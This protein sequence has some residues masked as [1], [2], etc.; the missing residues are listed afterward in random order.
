MEVEPSSDVAAADQCDV[1]LAAEQQRA[2][3]E[4]DRLRRE[5]DQ[6]EVQLERSE[7]ACSRAQHDLN[8]A[9][10]DLAAV[11]QRPPALTAG[12]AS[13]GS[14]LAEQVAA[15]VRQVILTQANSTAALY[16]DIARRLA[17]VEAACQQTT[18]APAASGPS[19][20]DYANLCERI[21]GL[22][23]Q[24]VPAGSTV[25]VISKGDD[26]LVQ[27]ADRRGW[28]FPQNAEG[29][30][31]GHH[32]A[33][34]TD[35]IAHLETLR[36]KG[37]T[38]LVVPQT[39]VWWRDFYSEFVNYLTAHCAT[40][41]DDPSIGLIYELG[42]SNDTARPAAKVLV[43][44]HQ[45]RHQQTLA[46]LG[47]PATH[48]QPSIQTGALPRL[49]AFY[50]PQYHPIPENDR[51]W[52]TGFTE[53]TNVTRA[54]PLFPGHY[55]PQLP[56]ELGFY[57]LRCLETQAA[58]ARLAA[59]FG[60]HGFCY[61]HYWFRG[62]RLLE[63]PF[64]QVLRTTQV[65]LPFCLCWA[66]EPWSRRWD[67]GNHEVL[68]AQSYSLADDHRHIR[69]LLPAL[70]DKRAIK[71][72]GCPIF[73]VYRAKDLPE[74]HRTVE[75]WRNEVKKAGLPGIHLIAV[76][77]SWDLGWDATK[78]GF[79]ARLLFQPC[80]ARLGSC[81]RVEIP[82]LPDLRVYDYEQASRL[83]AQPDPV[84]YRRYPSVFPNWDNTARAG[85]RAVV[86]RNSTPAA[87]ERWLERTVTE[88]QHEADEHKLI[89]INAWNE[90]AEGAHLEPDQRDQRGYLEATQRV[91]KRAAARGPQRPST[92]K[93]RRAAIQFALPP[94]L[95]E[96]LPNWNPGVLFDREWYVSQNPDIASTQLEPWDHYLRYGARQGRDPHPLFD[97][98]FYLKTY[99]QSVIECADPL[100]HYVTTG[101]K[102]G[103]QP[104]AKFDPEFYLS[105]YPDIAAHGVEPLTHFVTQGIKEGRLSSP[106]ELVVEPFEAEISISR[107]PQGKAAQLDP[108]I[109]PI[110]FFLPQFHAIP[111]NDKW[112]GKGFTEWTNVRS[113]K[114]Q[115]RAHYQPHVPTTL[116]YY[117]LRKGRQVLAEQAALAQAHGIYGF[118]LYYYWFA[119]K[120][121]L[122]LPLNR[123]LETGEPAMPFCICWANE[124]W[125]RRWDGM[126]S[127]ILIA[128]QHSPKDDLHFIRD[129]EHIL[130]QPNYIRVNGRPLLLVYRPS[131]LPEA[132][133]TTDRWREYFR[134]RGHGEICLALVRSHH[135]ER[136]EDY[137]FDRAVQFPPH[138]HVRPITSLIT[139]RKRDFKGV[140]H[141]YNY[142]KQLFL[143]EFSRE[144]EGTALYAGAMPSW[145]NTARRR[146]QANIWVNS[147]PES[148]HHWLTRAVELTRAKRPAEDRFLFIN[149]W[150]EWAEGCHLEP[151]RKYGHAWLNA[152]RLA[153]QLEP[154]PQPRAASEISVAAKLPHAREAKHEKPREV[155][156]VSHDAHP[157]GAQYFLLALVDWLRK[158]DLVRPKIMLA[159]PGALADEFSRLGPVFQF[160]A[161][162]ADKPVSRD[163]LVRA[164]R[165]FCGPN[166]AAVYVNSAAAGHVCEITKS[167]GVPH[168]AHVHELENSIKLW[169]GKAKMATLRRGVDKFI[170]A[171]S[172][173]AVNLH[174]KHRI[175]QEKLV[176]IE[177][178]IRCTRP[179][180]LRP[181]EKRRC[182]LALG[183]DPDAKVVIGCGTTDHRKGPDLFLDVA[184]RVILA[185][186]QRVQFVW[187]GSQTQAGQIAELERAAAERQLAG[188]VRF[189]GEVATPLPYLL[190]ADLFLLPS[191]EDPFPLVCLEAADCGLPIVCFAKAGGMPRFVGRKCGIV[192]PYLDVARMAAAVRTLLRDSSRAA[193]LGGQ[194]RAKVRA[195]HDISVIGR[196]VVRVLESCE[197]VP[198]TI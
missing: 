9:Q 145:D 184:E 177:E 21:R 109:K 93:G 26:A 152:T 114:R 45:D 40:L 132:R 193:R 4:L 51:W 116:G 62:Q 106:P 99:P 30:Y 74:P 1:H 78:H 84:A 11:Q 92:A 17:V 95:P 142:T 127:E 97:A 136:P 87:Y 12:T 150:N 77:T 119:G 151:D 31:Q 39:S 188:F 120:K 94:A 34:S 10:A 43:N 147:T 24:I 72:N 91:M 7:Q 183:L 61:Y 189:V 170:A 20:T 190:A 54:Q 67:G 5:R 64:E 8:L 130:T 133:A 25:A 148:Y 111:E 50:L 81:E 49:I 166:L 13:A 107:R 55:Q 86:F 41:V 102:L 156:F 175:P 44:G 35:A 88:L 79:D 27:F 194:A 98:K 52:G 80:W 192:T 125:T 112:W 71:V 164:L 149:A 29:M 28:H 57:D 154:A 105:T 38:H 157:H 113:A 42:G 123:M 143:D 76:E 108:T 174:T 89:F 23:E 128:Q 3:R 75:V 162:A 168:I 137:G 65:D 187:V 155:L 6:L 83:L 138:I 179:P 185:S 160:D 121:L 32:P 165:S 172:P 103:M 180:E 139:D 118:C 146:N 158:M 178:A 37:A 169:V 58:Q 56:S 182:K 15:A 134:K 36:R 144:P 140:I 14:N 70:S 135:G 131:L 122:D 186:R 96:P 100:R 173:V 161:A 33:N 117:D 124:N 167:L 101:W 198:V 48:R 69:A 47:R 73:L 82:E 163:R 90:W 18:P 159:G 141:D 16:E 63:R 181:A 53:W 110:A 66:N 60:I 196:E 46:T 68:Q 153:L 85:E 19:R 191:R 176:V 104:N 171:S 22:V 195:D 129:V 126:E 59:E 115:F 2:D 197:T